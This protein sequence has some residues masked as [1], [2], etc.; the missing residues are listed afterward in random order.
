MNLENHTENA[1]MLLQ[2]THATGYGSG[3]CILILR[4][5]TNKSLKKERDFELETYGFG[6]HK[7]AEYRKELHNKL[8]PEH[9][10]VM[11]PGSMHI[12]YEITAAGC[13]AMSGKKL[14][15]LGPILI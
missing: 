3:K 2:T 12:K 4:A 1:K 5:S 7:K 11:N 10:K 14:V 15:L 6:K 8:Q 13:D 9:L